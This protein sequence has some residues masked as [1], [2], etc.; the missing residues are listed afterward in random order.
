MEAGRRDGDLWGFRGRN[1]SANVLLDRAMR[2]DF[3]TPKFAPSAQNGGVAQ[4]RGFILQSSYRVVSRPNGQR[5]PVIHI[6]GR[7]ES[8]GTFLVRAARQRPH[9]FI[10]AADADRARALRI[11]PPQPSGKRTFDGAPVS[12]LEVDTPPEVPAVRDRLHKV[13]IETFEADVR[14]AVRYL[15]ERG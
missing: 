11:P 4:L 14:L 1:N 15:L 2:E 5:V 12:L 7:L 3:S 13:H 8:G 10:R 6:Y 9:F